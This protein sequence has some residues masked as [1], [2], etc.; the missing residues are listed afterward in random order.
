MP[1]APS[2]FITAAQGKNVKALLNL[3]QNLLKQAGERV[4]TPELNR[5]IEQAMTS[6]A[7]SSHENRRGKIYYATQIATHPPTIVLFCN[8]PHLFDAPYQRYLLTT[9]HERLPFQEVPVK[10]YLR[11]RHES[12][13]PSQAQDQAMQRPA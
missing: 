9:L 1:F 11:R 13:V 2:V 3:A 4:P 7:P 8:A 6:N 10:L 12:Q 5:V